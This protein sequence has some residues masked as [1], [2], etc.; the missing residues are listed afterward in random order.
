MS[1]IILI[2]GGSRS[3]KSAHAQRLAESLPGSKAFIATCPVIDAEM[4]ER[5]R[6]HQAQRSRDASWRTL[7][8]P[9]DLERAVRQA[10][11]CRVVLVD[12][13]T[14]WINNLLYEADRERQDL[15]EEMVSVAAQ[16]ILAAGR[17]LSGTCIFITNEVGLGIMPDNPLA[18]R[19][20]D[21]LGRCNQVMAAG[22]DEVLLLSCGLALRLK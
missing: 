7:E 20:Q 3:G 5:I 12:C 19:Y 16:K 18:R 9:L 14:L 21:L 2:T 1:R 17:E 6:L 22:A 13:L 4:A 15:T 10:T 11:D 8:E